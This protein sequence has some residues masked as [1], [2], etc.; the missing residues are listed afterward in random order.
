[1]NDLRLTGLGFHHPYIYGLSIDFSASKFKD[2]KHENCG[3]GTEIKNPK[4]QNILMTFDFKKK[5][6][7]SKKDKTY[8]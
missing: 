4:L 2:L 1:M 6:K 3:T 8:T 7:S 5:S